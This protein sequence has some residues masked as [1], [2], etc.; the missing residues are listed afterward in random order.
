[1]LHIVMGTDQRFLMPCGVL[2]DSIL[3]TNK[4]AVFTF[5]LLSED[6]SPEDES[7]LKN[8]M[9]GESSIVFYS[10]DAMLND[11]DLPVN[12]TFPKAIYYRLLIPRLLPSD[13]DTALYIDSDM[14]VVGS[15]T[16]LWEE[17]MEQYPLAACADIAFDDIR[18]FNRLDYE[19]Q[20]GYFN[21][22][23]LL[24]NLSLW[25][26]QEIA[27][28]LLQFIEQHK[29]QC[30]WADQ[31]AINAVLKG[32]IKRMHCRFN[33]MGFSS[34]E[35]ILVRKAIADEFKEA[36]AQPAI[37]H[38]QGEAKPWYLECAHPYKEVWRR[39]LLNTAWKDVKI[40]SRMVHSGLN[41]Y[42]AVRL[43]KKI[44]RAAIAPE[45]I[46]NAA[47]QKNLRTDLLIKKFE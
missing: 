8:C 24:F 1:M 37:L 21:S 20:Y 16:S 28:R 22:G 18:I 26:E 34:F 27:K 30:F 35:N 32:K 36:L 17:N 13:I 47:S 33:L 25:R 23:L 5:H 31:D 41:K 6:L 42:R 46:T 9:R 3:R 15:I 2:I 43:L 7:L 14:L 29:E 45:T 38:F 11:F 40:K 39:A 44:I 19:A 10:V 12:P 4:E